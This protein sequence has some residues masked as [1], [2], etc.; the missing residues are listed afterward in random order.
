MILHQRMWGQLS[1]GQPVRRRASATGRVVIRTPRVLVSG[2]QEVMVRYLRSTVPVRRS[3]C[4]DSARRGIE[5]GSLGLKKALAM[6]SIGA[7]QVLADGALLAQLS[8]PPRL[9][10]LL[11]VLA[12]A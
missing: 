4:R 3:V 12:F 10:G 9:T 1:R 7:L 6:R 11:V 8:P 2:C 5:L